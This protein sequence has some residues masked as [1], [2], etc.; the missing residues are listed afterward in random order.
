MP[1]FETVPVTNAF[2][3]G[4]P[5]PIEIESC[6]RDL[7]FVS[8]T[9]AAAGGFDLTFTARVENRKLDSAPL[10]DHAAVVRVIQDDVVANSIDV[11][12]AARRLHE[13]SAGLYGGFG[14]RLRRPLDPEPG[15]DECRLPT[16][17]SGDRIR[18]REMVVRPADAAF[19]NPLDGTSLFEFANTSP[20]CRARD[21]AP[22]TRAACWSPVQFELTRRQRVSPNAYADEI[23][24]KGRAARAPF[25]SY[26]LPALPPGVPA[27]AP[28]VVTE[29][30][31]VHPPLSALP[32][33]SFLSLFSSGPA[34]QLQGGTGHSRPAPHLRE[35]PF[36]ALDN[37]EGDDI[38]LLNYPIKSMVVTPNHLTLWAI[39]T[40][41]SEVMCFTN[42]S[43]NPSKVYPVPWDPVSLEYWVSSVDSHAE[44]LVV[45]RGT[46]GLTR[47]AP[48]NG[49]I[50]GYLPLP[51]EPGGTLL[52]GNHLFVTS[53]ALDRVVEIDLLT[54]TVF[55]TFDIATTRHLLFLSADGLGNVLVTPLLSGNNTMPR[56]SAVAGALASDPGGNIL[57]MANPAQG[58]IPLPDEDVFRIVP[59]A[60][61]GSGHVEVAAKGVGA[62]L[63]AHGV[64]P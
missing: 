9:P 60:T 63:F 24:A 61:P 56:H 4:V 6:V 36:Q 23:S 59:G 41:G 53:S 55:Q 18:S 22:N 28:R 37:V 14:G 50:L 51:A 5:N 33:L 43:G 7:T 13:L 47:L 15:A 34:A 46:Y 19:A 30:M 54:N 48:S 12:G 44:L 2:E 16:A 17:V 20:A 45:T 62:M 38:D 21:H 39:N 35:A 11:N 27:T 58:D 40:H 10:A 31:P 8:A 32:L 1:S 25:T 42:L 3:Q 29:V 57:D 49:A 52:L 26:P 64:N